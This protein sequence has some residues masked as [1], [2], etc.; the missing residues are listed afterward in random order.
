VSSWMSQIVAAAYGAV[1]SESW[2]RFLAREV[3]LALLSLRSHP[4]LALG[5]TGAG[6]D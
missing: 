5:A 1:C 3:D 6:A 4:P 2:A